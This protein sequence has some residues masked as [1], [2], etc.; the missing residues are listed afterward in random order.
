MWCPMYL[1][2]VPTTF[3]VVAHYNFVVHMNFL[4]H[5]F[6][7]IIRNYSISF[8]VIII[9]YSGKFDG[10]NITNYAN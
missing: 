10:R 1:D 2:G 3:S 4:M 6:Q 9:L 7:S 5:F 8:S